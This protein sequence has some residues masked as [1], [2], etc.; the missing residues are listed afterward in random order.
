M[1]KIAKGFKYRLYILTNETGDKM[2]QS[3]ECTPKKGDWVVMVND[4]IIACDRN[5]RNIVH[6]ADKYPDK[7]IITKEPSTNNCYY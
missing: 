5:P 6:I 3:K 1:I 7:A 4:R 2:K